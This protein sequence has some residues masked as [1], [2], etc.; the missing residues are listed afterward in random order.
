MNP[1]VSVICVCYNHERFVKEAMESALNQTYDH[2]EVIITDDNS[3]DN[4]VKKILALVDQNPG[5]QFLKNEENIGHNRTFNKAFQKSRGE[6]IID[7]AADDVLMPSRVQEGVVKIQQM[8]E[9]YGVHFSDAQIINED[10]GLIGVHS[11]N[12][13]TVRKLK[14]IPQGDVFADILRHY[15]ICPPTIMCK[16]DVLDKLGGYDESLD[17]EDFDF[18]VRSSRNFRFCYSPKQ[19][20]KRRIVKGSKSVIQDLKGHPY[21]E[22]TLRVCEKALDLIDNE[23]EKKALTSRLKYECRHVMKLGEREIVNGYFELMKKNGISST[24][25][26]QYQL[27]SSVIKLFE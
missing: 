5:I 27:A 22:S 17:Y 19:L 1:L 8:D 11:R 7:L 26:W 9:S 20:V 2:V 10:S 6:Y 15:F 21:H 3:T 13:R 18:L 14:E 24:I 4:S 16:R 12:T 25:L 23:S